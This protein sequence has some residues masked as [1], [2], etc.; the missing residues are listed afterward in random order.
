MGKTVIIIPQNASVS[1][2]KAN[3][4][5]Y[6]GHVSN[7]IRTD[8]PKTVLCPKKPDHSLSNNSLEKK[9]SMIFNTR[10]DGTDGPVGGAGLWVCWATELGASD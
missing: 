4:P 8:Y 7:F 10:I 3:K 9:L 5:R 2:N 1:Q 6:R